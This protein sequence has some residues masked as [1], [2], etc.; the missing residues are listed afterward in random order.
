M[1]DANTAQES[2][3]RE[4]R[5][6]PASGRLEAQTGEG[7]PEAPDNSLTTVA[8]NHPGSFPS[9]AIVAGRGDPTL[10]HAFA[11]LIIGPSK[12]A[13]MCHPSPTKPHPVPAPQLCPFPPLPSIGFGNG[14]DAR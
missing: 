8:S 10:P 9:R 1:R 3:A 4:A 5:H 14:G 7:L 11:G 6:P 2:Y 12:A 13:S